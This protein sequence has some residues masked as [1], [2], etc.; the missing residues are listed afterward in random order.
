MWDVKYTNVIS[1]NLQLGGLY[2][3]ISFL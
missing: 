1:E 3:F 2:M